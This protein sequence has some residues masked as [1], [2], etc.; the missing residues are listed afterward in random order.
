M[1]RIEAFV[2]TK[3]RSTLKENVTAASSQGE[4]LKLK[5]NGKARL[6]AHGEKPWFSKTFGVPVGYEQ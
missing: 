4:G 6:P 3:R 5:G 2:L 1:N